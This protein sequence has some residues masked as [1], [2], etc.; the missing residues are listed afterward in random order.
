MG[1][2]A[3]FFLAFILSGV[4]GLVMYEGWLSEADSPLIMNIVSFASLFAGAVYAGRRVQAAGWAHGGLVGLAYVACVTILGLIV[5]D[6]LAPTLVLC[7]RGALALFL[8][9][10]AG[11]VGINLKG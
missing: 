4:V 6:Q 5:F 10:V 9:A 11:T 7:E 2:V 8:G 1:T 3:A